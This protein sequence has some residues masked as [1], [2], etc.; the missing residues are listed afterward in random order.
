MLEGNAAAQARVS[1]YATAKLGPVLSRIGFDAK[2][3]EGPQVP[4]LRSALVSTLGDMGDKAVV[5]EANRR[6]AALESDPAALD[7]PLRGQDHQ[8]RDHRPGRL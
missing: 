3:G 4:V 5:A 7:G 8:R 6:F 2:A 1:A